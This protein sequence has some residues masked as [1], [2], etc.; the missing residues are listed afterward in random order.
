[1]NIELNELE[2][3]IVLS[4]SGG[5]VS[6]L[7]RA[8]SPTPAFTESV[9]RHQFKSQFAKQLFTDGS[10]LSRASLDKLR[11]ENVNLKQKVEICRSNKNKF[12]FL[13]NEVEV[14]RERVGKVRGEEWTLLLLLLLVL[15][16]DIRFQ[17]RSPCKT[18]PPSSC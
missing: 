1:M 2:M 16:V 9:R 17:Q 8:T 4:L 14:L 18:S 10:Q 12:E 15:T 6:P 5:S 13:Q 11:K 3:K 7:P